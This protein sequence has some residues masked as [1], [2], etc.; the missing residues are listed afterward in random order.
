MPEAM[1]PVGQDR[2]ISRVCSQYRHS[3]HRQYLTHPHL[4]VL[5]VRTSAGL[6]F[7]NCWTMPL[8]TPVC[9]YWA[10]SEL[11][12]N[13]SL[14]PPQPVLPNTSKWQ[15][16]PNSEWPGLPSSKRQW[17]ESP[18]LLAMLSTVN[19]TLPAQHSTAQIQA[20]EDTHKLAS[21]PMDKIR[22]AQ[23]VGDNLSLVDVGAHSSETDLPCSLELLGT[24]VSTGLSG[25][26]ES[27][28]LPPWLEPLD[29]PRPESLHSQQPELML[30]DSWAELK[31]ISTSFDHPVGRMLDRLDRATH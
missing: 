15:V 21:V 9:S 3:L 10:N 30:L 6:V 4:F 8:I 23:S 18:E 29:L 31:P 5:W 2:Q 1:E 13:P 26:A 7:A 25:A 17:P 14:G 16:L 20:F 19:H 12:L 24:T 27:L 28:D 22:Q 11:L